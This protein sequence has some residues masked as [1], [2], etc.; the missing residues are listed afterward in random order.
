[1]KEYITYRC[2]ICGCSFILLAEE[3][4]HNEDKGNYISCPFK[5]H[6]NIV[7]TGAYDSVKECMQE[8]SY[9]RE[10]GSIKQIK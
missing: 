5:G 6:K 1:M 7:V 2:K 9:K 8:R 10:R 3:T 4:K